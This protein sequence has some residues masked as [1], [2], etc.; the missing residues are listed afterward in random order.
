MPSVLRQQGFRVV[1]YQ[2]D[3]RP[4]HVHVI[5]GR[6]EVLINLGDKDTVPQ[7]RENFRMKKNEERRALRLVG[8]YQD[9]LI[10]RWIEIHG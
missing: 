6:A 5:K 10:Q 7:V 1:I 4:R 2:N 9:Y 3:H 8:H